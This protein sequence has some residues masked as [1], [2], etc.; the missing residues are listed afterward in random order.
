[1]KDFELPALEYCTLERATRF[2]G[3]G[4]EVEDLLHWAEIGA[5]N[6][7]HEF[8]R[9]DSMLGYIEFDGTL[10]DVANKIFNSEQR[11]DYYIN[12]S[13]FSIIA[14]SDFECCETV[15]QVAE[16]LTK[17]GDKP[18]VKAHLKGVWNIS[19]FIVNRDF[20][21]PYVK[22]CFSPLGDVDI[23]CNASVNDESSFSEKDLL[24]SIEAISV[25]LGDECKVRKLTVG[26]KKVYEMGNRTTVSK[27]EVSKTIANNRA[28]MI[29]ALLAIH[30]GDDVAE[31]PRKFIESKDSEICKDFQLRGIAL[32]SGKTIADWLKD[33]DIDFA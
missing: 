29:K 27:E 6:L 16:V 9:D 8:G 24:V 7:S 30:Y 19:S 26:R 2:I 10:M 17:Y 15:E 4:C 33:A 28:S 32:P 31:S 18:R 21:A 14:T 11:H 13:E 25:I 22:L 5:I 1:M 23:N 3:A 12:V 20:T